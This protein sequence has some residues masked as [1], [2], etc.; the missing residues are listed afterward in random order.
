MGA[1]GET[2]NKNYSN[3]LEWFF[4]HLNHTHATHFHPNYH[5]IPPLFFHPNHH[6]IPRHTIP[7]HTTPHKPHHTTKTTPC[8][9][10]HTTPHKPHHATPHQLRQSGVHGVSDLVGYEVLGNIQCGTQRSRHQKLPGRQ[11]TASQNLRSRRHF[12]LL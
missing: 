9:T 11:S 3:H 4:L 12:R 7:R 10:S 6:T 8:H 1:C 2:P 5:T